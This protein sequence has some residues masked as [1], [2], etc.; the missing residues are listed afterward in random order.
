M[1]Q[2]QVISTKKA[3]GVSLGALN[4]FVLAMYPPGEEQQAAEKLTEFWNNAQDDTF[5]TSWTFGYIEGL[6]SRGGLYD[7]APYKE[8][9]KKLAQQYPQGF[10]RKLA[11]GLTD[12]NYGILAHI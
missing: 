2:L 8:T 5:F 1:M 3:I 10:K 12:V 11:V 4:A 9:L 6:F 7:T